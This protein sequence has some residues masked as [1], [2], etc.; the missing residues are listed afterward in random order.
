MQSDGPRIGLGFS[1][2][3]GKWGWFVALGLLLIVL[4]VFA[5]VDVMA[6]TLLSVVFIG[7]MLLVGGIVQIAHAFMTRSWAAFLLNLLAGIVYAIGGVLIMDEPVEGSILITIFVGAML[8]V[9]GV[10]RAS[11]ALR[12]REV[13]GWWLLL[14][15]GLISLL[16]GVLLYASLP[17][18]G[19]W[20]LGTLIGVELV[21]HGA[22]WLQFGLALRGLHRVA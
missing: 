22:T 6:V 15:G 12:H 16:L 19:L 7:A 1:G 18:S 21:V 11:I 4:G 20:V 8:I 9:G 10:L 14:A 17:W 3:T 13:G 2:V 5:L